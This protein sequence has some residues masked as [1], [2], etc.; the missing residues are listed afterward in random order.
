MKI[1]EKQIR[2]LIKIAELA[3]NAPYRRNEWRA[4]I[5]KLLDAIDEQQSEELKDI[6][7][8]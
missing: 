6:S 7:D 3:S 4:E 2:K 8:E 5:I 1:S